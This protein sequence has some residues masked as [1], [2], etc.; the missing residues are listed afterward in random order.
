MYGT[1]AYNNPEKLTSS[2]IN[3]WKYFTTNKHC[4]SAEIN[5]IFKGIHLPEEVLRQL[6]CANAQRIYGLI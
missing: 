2:L 4:E 5:G 1:D 6:Y 3:D